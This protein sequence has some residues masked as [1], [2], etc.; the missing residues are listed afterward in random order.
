M[1][2]NPIRNRMG[3]NFIYYHRTTA[4]QGRDTECVRMTFKGGRWVGHHNFL[5]EFSKLFAW[6]WS[7]KDG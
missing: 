3:W 7:A 1:P 5:L 6:V 2:A 4:L